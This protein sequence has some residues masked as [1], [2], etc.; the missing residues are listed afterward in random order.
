MFA[1]YVQSILNAKMLEVCSTT[2]PQAVLHRIKAHPLYR[3]HLKHR[4]KRYERYSNLAYDILKN[5]KGL[6]VNRT[7]G[8]F[9]MSAV[10]EEGDAQ[11]PAEPAHRQRRGA[12]DEVG[13]LVSSSASSR[14]NGSSITCWRP[15][16][17]AWCRSRSPPTCRASASPPGEG[18]GRF[19][20]DLPDHRREHPPLHRFQPDL[21]S[22]R[23]GDLRPARA[24]HPLPPRGLAAPGG[25]LATGPCARPAAAGGFNRSGSLDTVF[26]PAY[27]SQQ[28]C[29]APHHGCMAA[30]A[31]ENVAAGPLT[32]THKEDRR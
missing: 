10:F 27:C 25:F 31:C 13:K 32:I 14:T 8:A 15:P 6:L 23:L 3:E 29:P 17:S 1:T 7:N 4:I 19:R 21:Q 22:L 28:I 2:L 30:I 9:Y 20:R 26:C 11:P 24:P 5:V 16:A 12:R 18:R